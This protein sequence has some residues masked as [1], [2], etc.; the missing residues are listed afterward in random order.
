M[1]IFFCLSVI[2]FS[3][4]VQ[5]EDNAA[6]KYKEIFGTMLDFPSKTLEKEAYNIIERGWEKEDEQLIVFLENNKEII[7]K[8]KKINEIPYCNFYEGIVEKSFLNTKPLPYRKIR[9]LTRIVLLEGRKEEKAGNLSKALDNYLLAL[10]IAH[11]VSQDKSMLTLMLSIAIKDMAYKPLMDYISNKKVS[12]SG[13]R[14][15]LNYLE[16]YGSE[17]ITIVDS[18]R[19]EKNLLINTVKQTVLNKKVIEEKYTDPEMRKHMLTFGQYVFDDTVKLL[20]YYYGKYEIAAKLNSK[21]KID[22]IN[23][24]VKALYEKTKAEATGFKGLANLFYEYAIKSRKGEPEFFVDK[25]AK[26]FV[27]IGTP[28]FE[29]AIERYYKSEKRYSALKEAIL[30]NY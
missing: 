29:P 25:I 1:F 13:R 15:L 4:L 19:E 7:K 30:N 9:N 24:E 12:K 11:D 5:A 18:I 20:N 27:L 21:E 16:K 8:M 28:N 2:C 17:K 10:K 14:K 22:E 23:R 6:E 26:L 3:R